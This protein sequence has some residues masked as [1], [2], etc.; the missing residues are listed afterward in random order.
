MSAKLLDDIS[1]VLVPMTMRFSSAGKTSDELVHEIED[2][3]DYPLITRTLAFQEGKGMIK[4]DSRDALVE[5]LSSGFPEKFFVT[6]FVDSRGGN[7]LSAPQPMSTK[8]TPMP[9]PSR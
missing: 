5:V 1:G 4:V 3:Y 8:W 9:S 6:E 2:Q 7:I